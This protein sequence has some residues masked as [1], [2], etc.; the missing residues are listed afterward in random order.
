MKKHYEVLEP[1][2][3]PNTGRWRKPKESLALTDAEAGPLL[4]FR[5]IKPK[6]V[7][8]NA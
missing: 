3:C 8:S 7:K 5:K 2:P 4:Q 1:F 6:R